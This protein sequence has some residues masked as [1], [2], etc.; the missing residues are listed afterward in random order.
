MPQGPASVLLSA[1]CL[2]SIQHRGT[3]GQPPEEEGRRDQL[4]KDQFEAQKSHG[5]V[6]EKKFDEL[7]KQAKSDPTA[8]KP[9][10]RDIDLD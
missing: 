10:V 5:K 7:F 6:L 3:L 8:G 2:S 4:F 1:G 9:R